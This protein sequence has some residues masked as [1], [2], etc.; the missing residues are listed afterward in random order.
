M[1]A[2][3][4]WLGL[5]WDEGPDVGGSCGPYRQSEREIFTRRWRRSSWRRT[6]VPVLLHGRGMEAMK[7]E[8]EAKKLPPKYA[9]KWATASEEEVKE[10]M[11]KG[12]P[13]T[14]RFACGGRTHRDRRH[15][16]RQGR[17]GHRYA[18]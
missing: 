2:D 18:R 10:M 17:M 5:D 12:V 14:Y 16:A 7:A 9:G 1:I 15:G 4:K 11:D 8:Q 13:F 3:L 6:R